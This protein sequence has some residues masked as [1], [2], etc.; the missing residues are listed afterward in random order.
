MGGDRQD[1]R[2]VRWI[3]NVIDHAQLTGWLCVIL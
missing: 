1:G 3:N 2:G